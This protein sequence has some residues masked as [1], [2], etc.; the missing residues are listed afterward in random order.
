[1]NQAETI[2]PTAKF[3]VAD[4]D[5]NLRSAPGRKSPKVGLVERDSKVRVLRFSSDRRWCE[6]E[7]LEHG[8]VKEDP[9]SADSGW[10]YAKALR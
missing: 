7:V 4:T 5:I 6:I 2:A 3:L 9:S 10:V 1:L 8:R